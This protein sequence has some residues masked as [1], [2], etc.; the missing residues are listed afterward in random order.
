MRI[1]LKS[2]KEK[3]HSENLGGP[4]S[5]SFILVSLFN[6]VTQIESYWAGKSQSL[7]GADGLKEQDIQD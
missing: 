5:I 2:T 7:T 6:T 3:K 1:I 4:K